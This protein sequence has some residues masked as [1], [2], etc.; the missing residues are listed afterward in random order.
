[1]KKWILL[2][3]T[4]LFFSNCSNEVTNQKPTQANLK[5]QL[6]S[7]AKQYGYKLETTKTPINIQTILSTIL[8][9]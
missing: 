2:L 5:T 4:V 7:I 8:M 9:S 1:M 3:C 6:E